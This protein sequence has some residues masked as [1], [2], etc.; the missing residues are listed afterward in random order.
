LKYESQEPSEPVQ[1]CAETALPY[2]Q[3]QGFVSQFMTRVFLYFSVYLTVYLALQ[4]LCAS[5]LSREFV[6]LGFLI[7]FSPITFIIYSNFV[8]IVYIYFRS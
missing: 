6:F 1:T 8:R 3:E 5:A 4:L 7:T 2:Y